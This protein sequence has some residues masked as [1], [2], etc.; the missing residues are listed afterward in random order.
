MIIGFDSIGIYEVATSKN[1]F[2]IWKENGEKT[3]FAVRRDNWSE[4]YYTVVEKI[5]IRKFP[6]GKAYG[7]P[8]KN[9]ITTDHYKYSKEWCDNK[10][11]PCAGCYQWTRVNLELPRGK[12]DKPPNNIITKSTQPIKNIRNRS[13]NELQSILKFGKHKGKTIEQVLKF[14]SSYVEWCIKTIKDFC[15]NPEG[16]SQYIKENT[17]EKVLLED[18]FQLNKNKADEINNYKKMNYTDPMVEVSKG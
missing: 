12:N 11:I 8:V 7:C 18:I 10:E 15:V 5:I 17:Q 16:L 13:I 9:G 3:P 1:I 14:E 6:Y 2:Q 4:K